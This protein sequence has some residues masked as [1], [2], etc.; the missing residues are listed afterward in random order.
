[1]VEGQNKETQT[2]LYSIKSI[3][4]QLL[5]NLLEIIKLKE[6][7]LALSFLYPQTIVTTKFIVGSFVGLALF[8][9]VAIDLT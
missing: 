2:V 9:V 7:G 6:K 1:M 3:Q 8:W 4:T 5:L